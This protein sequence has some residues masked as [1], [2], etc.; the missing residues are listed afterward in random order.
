M[1]PLDQSDRRHPSRALPVAERSSPA[2]CPP[3]SRHQKGQGPAGLP[4]QDQPARRSGLPAAR[5]GQD[6]PPACAG[7]GRTAQIVFLLI[8]NF[9]H[10]AFSCAIEPLRIANRVSGRPLFRWSL[11]SADGVS[12]ACSNRSVTLVDRG[13]EPLRHVDRLL[14]ISGDEVQ[15]RAT[16]DILGFLRRERAAGTP[17]GAICSGAY[18]LASAGFLTDQAAAIHWE[19]HDLVAEL[20]PEV[21]LVRGVFV[22]DQKFITAAGGTAAADLMLHLIAAEHG[23]DLATA[24]ADQMVYNA[25]REAT[26]EQRVS[27]QARHGTRNA[28]LM[29]AVE[30]VQENLEDPLSPGQIAD[31]LGISTRQIERLFQRHLGTSPKRFI[32][33]TRLTRARNLLVQTDLSITEVA[34]ACGFRT[35]STFS[36]VYRAHFMVSPAAQRTTLR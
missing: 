17:I 18:L 24:V 14:V 26:A 27:L 9:S 11:A 5:Q 34:V 35:P 7:Q 6:R 22:A 28:Y 16:P 20:F 30:L 19:Y 1:A 23:A 2:R 12:A 15:S 13:L 36:K 25:V 33:E 21:R 3:A 4:T 8:D 29:R 31:A 10:L 32:M